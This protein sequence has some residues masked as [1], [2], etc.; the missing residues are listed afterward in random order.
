ML[1]LKCCRRSNK[2]GGG[3]DKRN[4]FVVIN[5]VSNSN[6][7]GSNFEES[8]EPLDPEVVKSLPAAPTALRSTSAI[9]D[10]SR[11]MKEGEYALINGEFK[12]KVTVFF[13]GADG[14]DRLLMFV[15]E[16]D[17]N[18]SASSK[19]KGKYSTPQDFP[20]VKT[21]F[22]P[23]QFFQ[24][25]CLRTKK[26]LSIHI[27]GAFLYE[28]VFPAGEHITRIAS[29][30]DG[31]FTTHPAEP[32]QNLWLRT[33][34]Y[35]KM[36]D[37]DGTVSDKNDGAMSTGGIMTADQCLE[38]CEST[39]N[40]SDGKSKLIACEFNKQVALGN[41]MG[42]SCTAFYGN[43]KVAIDKPAGVASE[44]NCFVPMT[45]GINFVPLQQQF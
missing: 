15:A 39:V 25:T 10:I 2:I 3:P 45:M 22:I 34:G 29:F 37:D 33:T 11:G 27:N 17:K 42:A 18:I 20:Q 14:S 43:H 35:C 38:F 24:V 30:G 5:T 23:G 12:A 21:P 44:Y 26:G 41:K 36:V 28:M 40:M 8:A 9:S 19:I 32:L 7:Y 13:Y 6:L 31:G 16:T 4:P 1:G